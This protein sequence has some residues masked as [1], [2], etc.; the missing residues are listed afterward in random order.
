[1]WQKYHL[2]QP[3]RYEAHNDRLGA[4]GRAFF[5]DRESVHPGIVLQ[6]IVLLTMI[7]ASP[8]HRSHHSNFLTVWM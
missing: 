3:L 5:E 8:I 7:T 2:L 1:V 6:L 4:Q